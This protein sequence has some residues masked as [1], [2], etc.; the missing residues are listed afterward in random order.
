MPE[1]R[2]FDGC[3]VLTL[4]T[5]RR[6]AGLTRTRRSQNRLSHTS[7]VMVRVRRGRAGGR[8]RVRAR[9]RAAVRRGGLARSPN[10]GDGR[11]RRRAHPSRGPLQDKEIG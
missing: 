6:R 10:A 4:A 3:R 8:R 5:Q 2:S 1:H 7:D 11:G 9:H